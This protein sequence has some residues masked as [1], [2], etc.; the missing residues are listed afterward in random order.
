MI[1]PCETPFKACLS[2]LAKLDKPNIYNLANKAWEQHGAQTLT[3]WTLLAQAVLDECY[4]Q[5]W[6]EIVFQVPNECPVC[7]MHWPEKNAVWPQILQELPRAT[8][9]L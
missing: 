4:G 2:D 7:P 3:L 6:P 9:K 5:E 8:L 1:A